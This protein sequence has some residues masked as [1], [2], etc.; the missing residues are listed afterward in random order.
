MPLRRRFVLIIGVHRLVDGQAELA[1]AIGAIDCHGPREIPLA[2]L[3]FLVMRW[4]GPQGLKVT[5]FAHLLFA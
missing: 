1:Y 4:T 3:I 2:E 5:R